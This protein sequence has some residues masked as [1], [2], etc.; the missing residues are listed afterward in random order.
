MGA[1]GTYCTVV[2][3]ADQDA[4]LVQASAAA[5]V[6]RVPLLVVAEAWRAG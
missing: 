2:G 5:A 3:W 4:R 6:Q 1:A